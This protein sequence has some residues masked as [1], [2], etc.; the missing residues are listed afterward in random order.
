MKTKGWEKRLTT[1]L[2]ATAGKAPSDTWGAQEFVEGALEAMTGDPVL[3]GDNPVDAIAERFPARLRPMPG[4]LVI[5]PD[6]II[7]IWQKTGAYVMTERGWGV[8]FDVAPE[9]GFE[10]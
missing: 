2:A 8:A 9:Q 1:Y 7:G 5:L 4:D 10:V 3:L 6:G